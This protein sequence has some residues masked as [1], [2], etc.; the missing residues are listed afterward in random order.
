MN[1]WPII[2]QLHLAVG[3]ISVVAGFAALLTR[4]GSDFHRLSGKAFFYAMLI[5]CLSGIY[6]SVSRSLL[7]TFFIAFFALYLV[8][9]GWL[10]TAEGGTSPKRIYT[11]S[12]LCALIITFTSFALVVLGW[13]LKLDYPETEPPYPAYI[14]FV[15]FPGISA[16]SDLKLLKSIKPSKTQRIRRHLTRMSAGLLTATIIFFQGNSNILPAVFRHDIILAMPSLIVIL[17]ILYWRWFKPK[18]RI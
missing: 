8:I 3:T 14:I 13:L 5:L 15:L 17:L 9:T 12:F 18:L 7:F 16:F 4:K 2:A 11:L 6:M 1:E 10:A